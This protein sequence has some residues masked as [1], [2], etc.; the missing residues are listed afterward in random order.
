MFGVLWRIIG[1]I[2][3]FRPSDFWREEG[4]SIFFKK[5]SVYLLTL[6]SGQSITLLLGSGDGLGSGSER[7]SEEIPR[8]FQV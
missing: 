8:S 5:R 6:R 4:G 3:S 7:G 1:Y 2:K